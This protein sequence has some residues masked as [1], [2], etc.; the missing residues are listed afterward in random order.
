MLRKLTVLLMAALFSVSVAGL[1][2]AQDKPKDK[3]AATPA[4]PATPPTP[5]KK[6]GAV[7]P[8][9]AGEMTKKKKAKKKV[10]KKKAKEGATLAPEKAAPAKPAE[11]PKPAETK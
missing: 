8:C 11:P 3:P 9:A 10:A 2:F 6:E 5:A 1:S 7:N 4:V